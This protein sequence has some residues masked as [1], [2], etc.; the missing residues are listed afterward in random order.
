MEMQE[1]KPREY[2]GVQDEIHEQHLKMKDMTLK[3]KLKYFWYYYKFH[4]L[5]VIL[6]AF[7]IITLGHDILS[8]KDYGFYGMMLNSAFLSGEKMGD[9]FAEYAD[10]DTDQYDCF[11]DAQSTLSYTSMNE[12]DMATTQRLIALVQTGDLDAVVFDSIV[13][14]NYA[15]NE[16]FLDLRTVFTEEELARYRDN[17]Y[18]VDYAQIEAANADSNY[19]NEDLVSGEDGSTMDQEDILEE[20]EKHRHPEAMEKPVP[21]GIYIDD[22]AFVKKSGSYGQ[23]IPVFG[24]PT[25]T[26]RLDISKKY[27]DFLYDDSIPFEDM[28][29]EY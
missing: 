18:Y 11:I 26:T 7:F 3:E 4:T 19:V 6:V 28:L 17:L 12:Y 14:N 13:F 1:K 24:F 22:S 16:V 9:A 2:R 5:A 21:V 8:A 20:A 27:L 25:T 15:N 29:S 10:I 23:L